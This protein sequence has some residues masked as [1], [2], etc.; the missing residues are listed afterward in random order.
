MPLAM[1]DALQKRGWRFYCD[2]A[3]NQ[4]RFICSW[5]SMEEDVDSLTADIK[6]LL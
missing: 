4:A 6:S 5:D 1:I 3:P 2:L